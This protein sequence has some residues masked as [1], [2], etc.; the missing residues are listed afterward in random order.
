VI[1]AVI[2]VVASLQLTAIIRVIEKIIGHQFYPAISTLSIFYRRSCTGCG[3]CAGHRPGAESVGKL[4]SG[5]PGKQ[6]RS[7]EGVKRT[8]IKSK[9]RGDVLR[10]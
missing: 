10:I 5:T 1:G 8:I 4:V 7:G 3:V 9:R 6:Y 2:G